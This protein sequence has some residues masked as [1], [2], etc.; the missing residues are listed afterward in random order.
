MNIFW[1]TSVSTTGIACKGHYFHDLWQ[2]MTL[3]LTMITL[4]PKFEPIFFFIHLGFQVSTPEFGSKKEKHFGPNENERNWSK[5][6]MSVPGN[7]LGYTNV[8]GDL[9]S[10]HRF[11]CAVYCVKN[12]L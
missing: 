10:Y 3:K 9:R 12:P 2:W 4:M 8:H 6:A 7:P 5:G 1:E 11:S